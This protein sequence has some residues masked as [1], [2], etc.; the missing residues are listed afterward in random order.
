MRVTGGV[1]SGR[2]LVAPKGPPVRPTADHVRQALFNLLGPR[3]EGASVLDL[4]CGSGALGIEAISRGASHVTFVDRSIFSIRAVESNLKSLGLDTRRP[5][6]PYTLLR[7]DSPAA[8]KKL[9][10]QSSSFDLVFLDPPYGLDLA[11]KSLNALCR[12]AIVARTGLIAAE[13]ARREELPSS[14][15]GEGGLFVL[16]HS[17]SYGETK[18]SIYERQ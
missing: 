10:K 9:A 8:V 18:L 17:S 3:V 14:M 11:R 12:C 15:E 5:L 1:L 13:H 16:R 2:R 7:C 4:F 6:L